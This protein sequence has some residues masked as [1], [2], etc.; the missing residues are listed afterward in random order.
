MA[1]PRKAGQDRQN[2]PGQTTN[3][4]KG[5]GDCVDLILYVTNQTPDCLTAYG[6][7]QQICREQLTGR[8]RI[9]V[10]DL[11]LDPAIAQ[12]D[13]ILAIP[14]VIRRS[15][16]KGGKRVIGTLSDSQKVIAGLG[17]PTPDRYPMT[18]MAG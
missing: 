2:R 15:P 8:Y 18:S 1:G 4:G 10:I 7:L 12:R 11:E 17:L 5:P 14:T 6:N 13:G 3:N 16:G 9:T